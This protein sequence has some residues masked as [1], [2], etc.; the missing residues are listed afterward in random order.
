M[1]ASLA[2]ADAGQLPGARLKLLEA[3]D[4]QHR[5]GRPEH[6]AALL[7]ALAA[8][9]ALVGDA[10]SALAYLQRSIEARRMLADRAAVRNL[11]LETA[12][13][14]RS[15]GNDRRAMEIFVETLRLARLFKDEEGV[16]AVLQAML[17]SYRA[18]DDIDGERRA[19]AELREGAAAAGDAAMLARLDLESGMGLAARGDRQRA[20]QEL[21]QAVAD[22]GRARDSVLLARAL[23]ALGETASDAGDARQAL[24]YFGDALRVAYALPAQRSLTTRL[25]LNVGN[26][27]AHMR[28]ARSASRFYRAALT[29]ALNSRDRIA[30]GYIM[31]L[32]GLCALDTG[33]DA[34]RDCRSGLD[35]FESLGNA[36]GA[37]FGEAAMGRIAERGKQPVQAV[38]RYKRAIDLRG[39]WLSAPPEQDVYTRCEQAFF[40]EG[41]TYAYDRLLDVLLRTGAV[42][43]AFWY[44]EH[45]SRSLYLRML[46]GTEP[47]VKDSAAAAMI[48]SARRARG[49]R[50]AA[51][52]RYTRLLA[53]GENR[54]AVLKLA[55]QR[56]DA[57]GVEAAQVRDETAGRWPMLAPLLGVEGVRLPEVQRRL[58][59]AATLV[60]FVPTARSLYAFV[61][62]QDDATVRLAAAGSE[63]VLASTEQ[64]FSLFRSVESEADTIRVDAAGPRA[65]AEQLL[66]SLGEWFMLPVARDLPPG[67]TILVV[68]TPEFPWLPVHAL[69]TGRGKRSS[70]VAEQHPVLYL[71]LAGSLL[72]P[73]RLPAVVR[74]VAA[75]GFPGRTRWDVEYELRDIRAFFKD[76]RLYFGKQATVAELAGES[77]QLL[78]IAAQLIVNSRHP[79]NA[80]IV[81]SDGKSQTFPAELPVGA[82]FALPPTPAVVVSN[83]SPGGTYYHT[84][85][86]LL[87]ALNGT[88][89]T[90]MNGFVPLR[91]SK[92]FFNE[93]FYT[94]LVNGASVAAAYRAVQVEMIRTP[95]FQSPLV[96]GQYFLWS[97]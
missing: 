44:A 22:A 39:Q 23:G 56:L 69:R 85:V 5:H 4:E 41:P 62:T 27:Y 49:H 74:G 48:R 1:T 65:Q 14:Y 28:D 66:A 58:G 6:V 18:L 21:L 15:M 95:A 36:R 45:K 75:A 51:E 42:G 97:R 25:L 50:I 17:P 16:R 68:A 38:E 47:D 13:Q 3:V 43:D 31:I 92:K 37:A 70:Y 30:E 87:L 71:P 19:I 79:E 7:E 11:T 77:S 9:H 34:V 94:N 32:L 8:S 52:I 10:D 59:T 76:A 63:Q 78:H 12:G 40:P 20:S 61:V 72:L 29:Y 89:T 73:P 26:T 90:I 35:L 96:W 60:R 33:G 2:A 54:A 86:P 91:R 24:Q 57:T 46:S 88:G 82:L 81:L 67:G 55:R 93:V 80:A 83:L 53:D 64:L 84:G